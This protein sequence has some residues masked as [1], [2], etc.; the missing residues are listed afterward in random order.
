MHLLRSVP[1][2]LT[3]SRFPASVAIPVLAKSG[4]WTAATVVLIYVMASDV[5]D[6]WMARRFSIE[7]EFGQKVDPLAD[8]SGGLGSLAGLLLT[9]EWPLKVVPVAAVV[10]GGLQ[11]ISDNQDQS[12]L[13][14]RLKRHQ[15]YLH[16]LFSVA[17][18]FAIAKRYVELTGMNAVHRRILYG[19]VGVAM[20]PIL[21]SR[22]HRAFS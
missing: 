14:R 3:L 22:R 7:S 12:P 2:A 16:P 21:W 5:L 17:F 20:I 13:L 1:N 11:Y 9:K 19:T 18:Q 4:R 6:G 8:F 15:N 10:S